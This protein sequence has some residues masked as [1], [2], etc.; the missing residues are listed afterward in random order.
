MST[1]IPAGWLLDTS[2]LA[3][4]HH[5]QAGASLAA[6]L[7]AGVLH[8]CPLLDLEALAVAGSPAQYRQLSTQRQQAY[9]PVP[10]TPAVSERAAE[11]QAALARHAHLGAVAPADLLIAAT[12]IEHGLRVLH[13]SPAFELLGQVCGLG[14]AAV[15]PL[16]VHG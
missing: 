12:A 7:R 15:L 16:G 11:L 1:Q 2:A 9:R 6:L 5:P 3:V 13:H 10:F 14:Q 8:T 4:A